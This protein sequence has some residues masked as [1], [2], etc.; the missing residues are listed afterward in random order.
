MKK[1]VILALALLLAL[2]FAACGNGGNAASGSDVSAPATDAPS[3]DSD[4]TVTDEPAPAVTTVEAGKLHMSTNASFPPYEMTT[5]DGGFEGIDVEIA[6]AVAAKLGL[7]LVVDDMGFDAALISAQNGQSDMVMAGVSVTEARLEVMDFSETYAIGV[8]VIIVKD[9]SPI[10]TVEDLADA[11]MIG[12]QK[13]TTGYIY[14]SGDYGE[15]HVTAYENGATAVMALLNDQVDCVV[16][17]NMPAQEFVAN[18]PGLKILDTAYAEEEYAIG[19]AKG[20]TQLVDA[21]NAALAEL[22]AEGTIDAII[23]KYIHN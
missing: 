18:N 19:F 10:E 21:V 16:I 15:D 1:F 2:S 12:T 17:D 4:V 23:E 7:E 20:N 8:Q 6:S 3:T 13:A 11:A 5:D 22:R 9:G 14:C